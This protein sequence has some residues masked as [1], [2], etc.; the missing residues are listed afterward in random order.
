MPASHH[1]SQQIV[2]HDIAFAVSQ[3]AFPFLRRPRPAASDQIP[4]EVFFPYADAI[5]SVEGECVRKF[6]ALVTG[7]SRSGIG[8]PFEFH[9][10]IEN[11]LREWPIQSQ[12]A[13]KFCVCR[14]RYKQRIRRDGVRRILVEL[15]VP[16]VD[17]FPA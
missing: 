13:A 11:P 14:I 6:R 2:C 8:R 16:K 7:V 5:Q 4:P 9:V 17:S 1:R 3:N 12:M 15:V 10:Q